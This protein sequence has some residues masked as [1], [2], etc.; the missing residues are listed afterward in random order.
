[1]SNYYEEFSKGSHINQLS[2][3]YNKDGNHGYNNS[4]NFAVCFGYYDDFMGDTRPIITFG[5]GVVRVIDHMYVNNT[6]YFLNGLKGGTNSN[7]A[8]TEDTYI[9][10]VVE[11]FDAIGQSVGT[12]KIRLQDGLTSM[13]EWTKF[14]LSP[15]GAVASIKLGFDA[16]SDQFGSYGYAAPGYVAIDNIAVRI[17]TDITNISSV[18]AKSNVPAV[19]KVMQNGSLVIINDD[20]QFNIGGAQTK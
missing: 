13:T 18:T 8:A 11:G 4:A 14:D 2:V 5:D 6:A 17:D 12:A 20:K 7:P 10:L 9:D 15:L 19:R 16:S 1:M 3:N